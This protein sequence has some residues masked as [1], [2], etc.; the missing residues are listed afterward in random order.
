MNISLNMEEEK[1]RCV[2]NLI[3]FSIRTKNNPRPGYSSIAM[4][5]AQAIYF[6]NTLCMAP[7]INVF[8]ILRNRRDF[9]NDLIQ[10][11]TAKRLL[12]YI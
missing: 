7:S 4:A 1:C 10:K 6:K 11:L 9:E 12:E 2:Q 3:F 8:E 5:H